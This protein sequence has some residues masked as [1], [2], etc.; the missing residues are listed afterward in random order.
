MSELGISDV[1][2][3]D[4]TISGSNAAYSYTKHSDLDLHI[5]VDMSRFPDNEV[6]QELFKAKKTIY[7]DSHNITVHGIPVEVYVQD[8]NEPV[9]S[10]GEYS[11][12]NNRWIKHPVKRRANFDQTATKAK[13]QKLADLV[14]LTLKTKDLGR[15]DNVLHMIK[16]YRQAGLSKGGEFSPENLAYKAVRSQKGIDALYNLRDKLRSSKLSIEEEIAEQEDTLAEELKH[17][18]DAIINEESSLK[19]WKN[20]TPRALYNLTKK[21]QHK[22]LRGLYYSGDTYWWDATEAIHGSGAEE[23]GIPYDLS[24]IHI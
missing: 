12:L 13:Y 4:V 20:P 15:L 21:S 5:V 14:D 24:L 11:I 9:V 7:N 10:L 1:N 8:S 22:H 23:L 18:F 6:Y 2:V 19:H 17:Q 3:K 16:R